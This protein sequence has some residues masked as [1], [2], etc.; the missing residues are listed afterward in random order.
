[1]LAGRIVKVG[2]NSLLH[3]FLKRQQPVAEI[4]GGSS[5]RNGPANANQSDRAA[6]F[7]RST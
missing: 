5:C 3:F 1:M 7:G 4:G 6:A 2:C